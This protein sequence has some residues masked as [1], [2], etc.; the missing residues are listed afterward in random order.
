MAHNPPSS[1]FRIPILEAPPP[2]VRSASRAFAS[3]DSSHLA[4]SVIVASSELFQ[5]KPCLEAIHHGIQENV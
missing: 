4:L 3:D 5:P 2:V 1:K